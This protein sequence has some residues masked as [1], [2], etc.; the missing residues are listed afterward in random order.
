MTPQDLG[1]VLGMAAW[2]VALLAAAIIIRLEMRK[3]ERDR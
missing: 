1:E 3:I 2:P